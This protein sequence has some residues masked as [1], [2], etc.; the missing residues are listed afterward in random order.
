[1]L[2]SRLR[3][4]KNQRRPDIIDFDKRV[5][6][7]IKTPSFVNEGMVQLESYYKVAEAVLHEY[8]RFDEPPWHRAD[9]RW[10]PPRVLPY[11]SN[12]WNIVCTQ[13]TDH[14]RYPGLILYDVRRL[15]RQEMRERLETTRATGYEVLDFDLGFVDF[16]RMIRSELEKKVRF[17]DPNNSNY[18]I[19]VP[20]HLYWRWYDQLNEPVREKFRVK[21][22]YDFP[23]GQAVR[24]FRG[25]LFTI[26]TIAAGMAAI[27]IVVAGG[28]VLAA[29]AASAAAAGA[30]AAAAGGGAA[31]AGGGEVIS[32]AAY[33]AMLAAP[34]VRTLAAAAGVLVVLGTVNNAQAGSATIG[35]TDAIRVVPVA[36][37]EPDKGVQSAT[38]ALEPPDSNF[39]Q[40]PETAK[41]K[42]GLGTVVHFDGVRHVIIGQVS[43]N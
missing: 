24:Q 38:S 18:I 4:I 1:M 5:F 30:G 8:A 20:Q 15:N 19:I 36:E 23:G 32:L 12:P 39:I 41:G 13:A 10:N 2:I 28:T 37:F 34:R 25:Q 35:S 16:G 43:V 22:S 31:A 33:R 17:Y 21:P 42:F 14:T 27:A 40:T 6:Y 29:V 3:G 9:A 7:E 11:P 26:S